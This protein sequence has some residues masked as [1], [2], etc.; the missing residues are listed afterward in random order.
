MSPEAVK[1]LREKKGLTQAEVAQALKVT[2]R[3]VS[4]WETGTRKVSH[5]AEMALQGLKPKDSK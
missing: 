1:R 3:T 2:I 5:I 4:R